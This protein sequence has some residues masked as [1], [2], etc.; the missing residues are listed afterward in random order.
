[1]FDHVKDFLKSIFII[2]FLPPSTPPHRP[3]P[4]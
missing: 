2:F 3:Q 1:M 4:P